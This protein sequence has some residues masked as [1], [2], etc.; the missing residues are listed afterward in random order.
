MMLR[1]LSLLSQKPKC[2]NH[3]MSSI[4]IILLAKNKIE[5]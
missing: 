5:P 2:L 1:L 3:V 4:L